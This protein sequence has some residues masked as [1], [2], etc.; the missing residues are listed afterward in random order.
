M[1]F[2]DTKFIKVLILSFHLFHN[3]SF[4][5]FNAPW[6]PPGSVRYHTFSFSFNQE[7]S[8]AKNPILIGFGAHQRMAMTDKRVM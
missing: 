8:D 7:A 6:G 2:N 4:E 1:L 5:A 3:N